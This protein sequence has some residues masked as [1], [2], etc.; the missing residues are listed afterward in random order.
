[1]NPLH[2]VLLVGDVNLTDY[3]DG[4]FSNLN[5]L[6]VT[7]KAMRLEIQQ[8]GWLAFTIA[9]MRPERMVLLRSARWLTVAFQSEYAG[10][11]ISVSGFSIHCGRLDRKDYY[12]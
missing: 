2:V 9:N 5:A 3:F 4:Q 10:Q 1:M 12:R 7:C 6:S 8:K 11:G